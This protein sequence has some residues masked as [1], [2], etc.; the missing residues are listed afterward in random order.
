VTSIT[1]VAE[2][3]LGSAIDSAPTST[4]GITLPI[5][6]PFVHPIAGEYCQKQEKVR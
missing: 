4:T 1:R 2:A 5:S 6:V 3:A